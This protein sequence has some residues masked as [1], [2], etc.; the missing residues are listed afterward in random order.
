VDQRGWTMMGGYGPFLAALVAVLLGLAIGKAWERYKL[1]D[2]RWVDRRKTRESPHYII[3][4]NFLVAGQ[5]DRA[6][7]ELAQAA[8]LAHD[9]IEI[10]MILGNL[11]REKGQVGRAINVHQALLQR[12]R[13][14]RL[15]H[16]HV[17]LCLG[18]DFR[19]SGFIERASGSTEC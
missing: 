6:I 19:R 18:L 5:L 4:L 12:P 1:H 14:T 8:A 10:Q 3:G 7:D 2:G 13:L 16:A 15:E 9:A 17:L 11:Y